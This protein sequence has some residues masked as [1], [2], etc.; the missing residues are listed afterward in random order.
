MAFVILSLVVIRCNI[1]SHV[2]SNTHI[3]GLLIYITSTVYYMTPYSSLGMEMS[4]DEVNR[5]KSK[6]YFAYRSNSNQM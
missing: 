2:I 3:N 5:K 4:T 6:T 1:I